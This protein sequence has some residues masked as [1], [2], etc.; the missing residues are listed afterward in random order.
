MSLRLKLLEFVQTYSA[1]VIAATIS[2]GFA[3]YIVVNGQMTGDVPN[4]VVRHNP[5]ISP[6]TGKIPGKAVPKQWL[7][8][9][10]LLHVND[11]IFTGS[12]PKDKK[13]KS[14]RT[15]KQDKRK[16]HANQL[17]PKSGSY[18]LRIA[19]KE[20]ALVEGRG[21]LWSVRPG[22]LLPGSGRVLEI[23]QR[24]KQWV[25]VTTHGEIKS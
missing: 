12:L 14:S 15:A 22:G 1:G 18:I 20:L 11:R 24:G 25:V 10:V 8:D 7:P 23:V 9:D 19:T 6:L 13:K 16:I 4:I 3:S 17:D 2:T 5:V 21:K